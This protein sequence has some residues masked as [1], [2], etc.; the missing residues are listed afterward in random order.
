MLEKS[1]LR[2]PARRGFA[3]VEII[4]AI[5]VLALVSIFVLEMFIRSANMS[6]RAKDKDMA[7]F[8]AQTV[9][10]LCQSDSSRL[11]EVLRARYLDAVHQ[12]SPHTWEIRYNDIWQ[13]TS[14]RQ[15]ERFKLTLMAADDEEIY[16]SGVWAQL[17][18]T[19]TQTKAYL[20]ETGTRE[21][22]R[23][24]TGVY[25]PREVAVN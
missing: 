23:L 8:E 3:L 4:I 19:V 16:S 24:E 20:M 25:Q 5:G 18:T 2:V 10:A 22:F 6:N 15:D 7:C 21:I 11:D 13:P 12:V 1:T 14:S 9:V 17:I